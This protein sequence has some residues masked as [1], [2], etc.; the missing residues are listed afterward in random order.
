MFGAKGNSNSYRLNMQNTIIQ[1]M[2]A[3]QT[4]KTITTYPS[5]SD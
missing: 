5:E 1:P 2:K 3:C 4:A